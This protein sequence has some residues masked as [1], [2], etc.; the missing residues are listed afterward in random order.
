MS[1]RRTVLELPCD[2][3]RCLGL[4]VVVVFYFY[5]PTLNDFLVCFALICFFLHSAPGS[6]VYQRFA[7]Y[8][9][10]IIIIIIYK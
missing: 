8:K 10:L 7:L 3:R 9:Y 1:V 5:C 6:G 2:C 4:F